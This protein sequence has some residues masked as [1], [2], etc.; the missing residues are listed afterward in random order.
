M[1][2]SAPSYVSPTTGSDQSTAPRRRSRARVGDERVADDADAVRVGDP[3]DAAEQ[4]RLADPLEPGE[5]AVAVEPV[6]AR[7]HG[8]GP[9]VVLVR[10]D[11][12]DAGPDRALGRPRAARR[13]RSAS[14]ARPARPR[15]SVIASCA[16]GFEQA[17]AQAQLSSAHVPLR[18]P[19]ASPVRCGRPI[20]AACP[21]LPEARLTRRGAASPCATCVAAVARRRRADGRRRGV[22]RP[23]GPGAA[24]ERAARPDRPLELPDR[25]PGRGRSTRPPRARTR[26]PRRGRCWRG[27]RRRR[28]RRRTGRRCR[29]S[30][31]GSSASSATTSA[32]GSSGCRRSPAW[33]STCRCSGSR[34]TTGRSPGTGARARRGS[35]RASSTATRRMR[36]DRRPA[37]GRR[38][39]AATSP[40]RPTSA[41]DAR[42]ERADPAVPAD[43][44]SALTPHDALAGSTAS[45]RSARRS[46]GAR[47]TRR[48]SPAA[49]RRRS[50]ATRGRCSAGCGPATRRCSPATSTSARRPPPARRGRCCRP[51]RS[52]SSSV[53]AD[54]HRVAPTRSRAPG[55][56]AAPGS[57][58]GRSPASCSASRKD[59][60]ENVMIVDVLRN[61]LGRVCEP[62]LRAGAAAPAPRAHGGRPA[63]RHH[64]HRPAP[65][66]TSTRSTSSR[67]RSPAARSPARPKI[68]AMELI[69]RLEPVRRGPYCGAMA[70]AGRR[71]PARLVDPHP[72][73]RRGR[74][75]ADA[76]RRRRDHVAQRP[77]GG[78]G[79][80]RRQGARAAVVDRGGR[81]PRRERPATGRATSGSTARCC[82]PTSRTSRC[83]TAASSWATGSSRRSARG[84][85]GVTELA[86][87]V[88]RLRRLRRRAR[89]S[90]CRPTLERLLAAGDRRAARGRGPGRPRRRRLDPDHRLA[91]L[92]GVARPAAAARRAARRRRS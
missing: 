18:C 46:G 54:G 31:A 90:S 15:T 23:A 47:S 5:L 70:V 30:R 29:R 41:P 68:R 57:R 59:Q 53:D 8:L 19:D 76:P 20:I 49:S 83:S 81:G 11:D 25:R 44:P 26:S 55:R 27:W 75:A 34:C 64:G 61:D 66:R 1:S 9:D 37:R 85:A 65:R 52:R 7:E 51:R 77:R 60:A 71:R 32:G 58:T 62:G 21:Q 3:D 78:V 4:P 88:A 43:V 42:F 10:D 39:V 72:D 87:H 80:D 82:R 12:R 33:T 17:D 89:R 50:P 69:E 45:R 84:A 13:P 67:P 38:A 56:G 16:P 79:R 92:V 2:L 6:A 74:R 28:R 73:V 91:R 14:R 63:P 24:R 22:P 86:E 48:T 36:L 35:R 40:S